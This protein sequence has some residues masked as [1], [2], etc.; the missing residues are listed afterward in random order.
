MT[1]VGFCVISNVAGHDEARLLEAGR[2]FHSLPLPV[3]H[4]MALKHFKLGH[5]KNIN[6]GYFP[7]LENDPAHK[8]FFD[9]CR[10]YESLSEWERSGSAIYEPNTWLT[11]ED[12]RDECQQHLPKD[13]RDYDWI[14]DTFVA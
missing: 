5:G 8:E 7:F 9:I 2:A 13:L 6:Q 1:Q 3:K 12:I 14:Y 11:S 10:P 4:A